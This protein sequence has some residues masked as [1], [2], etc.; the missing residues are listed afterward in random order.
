MLN[1]PKVS[2]LLYKTL[3]DKNYFCVTEVAKLSFKVW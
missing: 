3:F 2:D 1:D